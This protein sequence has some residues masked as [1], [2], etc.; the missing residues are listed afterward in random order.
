MKLCDIIYIDIGLLKLVRYFFNISSKKIF[1]GENDIEWLV[2]KIKLLKGSNYMQ[3][4]N[5]KTVA[6]Y[7]LGCP[8]V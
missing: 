2:I 3:N 5:I 1:K 4:K 7:T 6:F 8:Y